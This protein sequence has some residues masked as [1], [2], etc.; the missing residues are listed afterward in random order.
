M[1]AG[2]VTVAGAP[3]R[4]CAYA[5]SDPSSSVATSVSIDESAI[6]PP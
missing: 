2:V 4:I 3:G 5:I 1:G 6:C